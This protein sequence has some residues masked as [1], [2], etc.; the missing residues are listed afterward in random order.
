MFR[1]ST[2]TFLLLLIII[3]STIKAQEPP[4]REMRASWLTTVWGLD[5]PQTKIPA[6]GGG[7]YIDAQ[8]QQLT[9]ILD[10]MKVAGMNAVFLSGTLRMRCDV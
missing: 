4:K 2:L 8:K 6:G 9:R 7:I 1:N 5:W 10:S 3:V